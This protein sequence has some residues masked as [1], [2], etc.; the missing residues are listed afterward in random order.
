[1]CIRDRYGQDS[2]FLIDFKETN[3][4]T[5]KKLKS[6]Q[7]VDECDGAEEVGKTQTFSVTY[8]SVGEYPVSLYAR[9]RVSCVYQVSKVAVVQDVIEGLQ[10]VSFNHTVAVNA[11]AETSSIPTQGSELDIRVSY[12]DGSSTFVNRSVSVYLLFIYLYVF[13][14]FYI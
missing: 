6:S 9:N 11:Q 13:Q 5:K 7:L 3:L 10:F 12:G 8:E 14:D 4:G 1:M 2:C